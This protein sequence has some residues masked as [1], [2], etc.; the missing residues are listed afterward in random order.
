MQGRWYI[1]Q[2]GT[3]KTF[4]HGLHPSRWTALLQKTDRKVKDLF[5][6]T[7]KQLFP[8]V[9]TEFRFHP[10][11]RWRFDFSWPSVFVA[12]EIEGGAFVQGRHTRGAGY[13]KDMEKYSEAAILGWRILRVTPQQV[14][15]GKAIELLERMFKKNVGKMAEKW[16]KNPRNT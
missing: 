12:L 2:E 6:V 5:H 16:R 8:G 7:L 15:N 9:E 10:E 1:L 13:V 11:R 14:K 3:G 4:H